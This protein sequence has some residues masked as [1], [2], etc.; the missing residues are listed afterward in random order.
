MPIRISFSANFLGRCAWA[1]TRGHRLRASRRACCRAEK[2]ANEVTW[3]IG[4]YMYGA[5]IW[6]SFNLPGQAAGSRRRLRESAV[7]G[8]RKCERHLERVPGV[9][10]FASCALM[11]GFDLASSKTT[12]FDSSLSLECGRTEGRSIVCD[13]CVR[14]WMGALR[15]CEVTT[16]A[17]VDNSWIYLN[18]ALINQDTGQ[19]WDFGREVS[20]YYGYDSDGSWTEGSR[21]DSRSSSRAFPRVIIICAS[22]LRW[23]PE[24]PPHCLY[25]ASEA[26]RH[27]SSDCSALPF[28][29]C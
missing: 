4:E 20:Y 13:R 14:I 3:S 22:S 27:R 19:A 17:N 7:A 23:I 10:D 8:Q 18:Y 1:N 2:M 24:H 5:D 6:K 21:K 26:R 15:T 12:V 28:W 25:C 16:S 11:A 29:R 9:R